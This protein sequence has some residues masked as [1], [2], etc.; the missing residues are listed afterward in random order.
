MISRGKFIGYVLFSLCAISGFVLLFIAREAIGW[1]IFSLAFVPLVIVLWD[2]HYLSSL[3]AGHGN[4][5]HDRLEG[6]LLAYLPDNVSPKDV[7]DALINSR[8]A[9]FMMV[10][11]GLAPGFLIGMSE[12]VSLQSIWEVATDLQPEG[13]V[14]GAHIIAAMVTVSPDLKKLLPH[15]QL[16]ER[17]IAQVLVWRHHLEE[18]I[19]AQHA[20]KNTG[21]IARDW[22]FGYTPML[23]R[24]AVN[25]SNQVAGGLL[26]VDIAA[27]SEALDFLEQTIGGSGRRGAVLVGPTGAGKTAVIQAFADRIVYGEDKVPV[28]LKYRQVLSLDASSLISAASGRGELEELINRLL[29]EAYHAKNTILCFDEAQYFFEEG[30][31]SVDLSTLL[32]PILEGGSLMTIFTMDEQRY[33]QIAQKNPAIASA[34]SRFTIAPA[35]EQESLRVMENKLVRLESEQGTTYMFQALKEAY[36]LSERYYYDLAQPGKSLQLLNA[37]SR[38]ASNG[39]V[40]ADSVRQAVEKTEGVKVGATAGEDEKQKL[41]NLESLIHERMINQ[42]RAVSV[43]SDA[44]R[45]AR[46]GVRNESRPIGTFLFLG[47][48]GVGKTELA[49]AL[50]EVY[51]GGEE[52]LIRLDM[53]E[54]V[55]PNDVKRL[56][57]DG[58]QDTH[59]LTARVMKQPFSVI[60]LD[61]LEKAHDQVLTTLL[62]VLDEGILRDIRG[63][64]VNFRD[65]I[66]IATSNA[67]A[68]QI[69]HHIEAGENL[70]KFEDSFVDE[71]ISS[72]TFRP[73]FL[74]RFD[75]IVLFRPL[76]PVELEQIVDLILEG[77]NET[78]EPQK[79]KVTIDASL[80]SWLVTK[81]NDPRLGARP[82]R[83]IVQKVVENTIAKRMLSGEVQPG[84]IVHL[85]EKDIPE[86]V[87]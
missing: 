47:P 71:L 38:F 76:K 5:I 39:I 14:S 27:H 13:I 36:R 24:F 20:P 72:K 53:N 7:L 16:D 40:T 32:L 11:A 29:I 69:R 49:K 46:A 23:E 9:Q 4:M 34:L 21:G 54:F 75:E 77:I 64:E 70:E 82:M 62:Q 59:S 87:K 60:L 58:A 12:T 85:T 67:G 31:G 1:L 35:S 83:R 86:A 66:I 2:T 52:H 15:L 61:E 50:A 63:R 33:L 68:Q 44:L 65:T 55:S 81:G 26:K 84:E 80:R 51:F 48:T 56:I 73:E 3:P 79:V 19:A 18:L 25:V 17:D 10:R 43:V 37:A 57:A 74:N 8:S 6:D 22:S 45:R 42:T 78:L 30:V 41:L 28:S